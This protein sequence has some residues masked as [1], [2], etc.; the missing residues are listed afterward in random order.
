MAILIKKN[1]KDIFVSGSGIITNSEKNQAEKL[2][3]DL[4]DSISGL[5][6]RFI[7][8]GF[9]T[10]NGIKKD[11][12]RI[13]YEMGALLNEKIDKYKI[14]GSA[15]EPFFWQS[16]Y[17]YASGRIQK[18]PPPKRSSDWKRNHFRLCAKMA[19][20]KWSEVKEVGT[21]SVWRDLF[22]NGKILEDNRVLDFVIERIKKINTGHKE[23]RPF[24]H[25]IRRELKK[26]DTSVLSDQ[27]L[28]NKLSKI[29]NSTI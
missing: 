28:E 11:V 26:V 5:E 7:K 29:F 20:R 25:T 6:I 16:V 8:R 17:D 18:K 10:K 19:E 21:W 2:S 14:R 23:L 4:E 24:I 1:K 27:E 12:L 13:W 15:D 22:D 9:L 3:N